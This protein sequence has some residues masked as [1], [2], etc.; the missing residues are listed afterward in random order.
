MGGREE[1]LAKLKEYG[2]SDYASR[3]YLALLEIGRA[4][5]RETSRQ[6]RVPLAKIYAVLRQLHDRGL[7]EVAAESPRKYAPR[8]FGEYLA[9]LRTEHDERSAALER[10]IDA[11]SAIFPE[12]DLLREAGSGHVHLV[13][14]RKNVMEKW[15]EQLRRAAKKD[16]LILA[17]DGFLQRMPTIL[18]V[19][20]EFA[21]AGGELK[22]LAADEP[23]MRGA[24]DHLGRIA[25]LR[26]KGVIEI[27]HPDASITLFDR[28]SA[29]IAH[30]SSRA[31]K[32]DHEDFAIITD[33]PTAVGLLWDV[34]HAHWDRARP[35][36]RSEPR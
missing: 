25:Q 19:L 21:A 27:E 28:E 17:G 20:E 7:V 8:P 36:P 34:L 16:V 18:P 33:L 3:V 15:R 32:L 13:R 12:P 22:V 9:K 10:D 6:S 11:A 4:D 1:Q 31:A 14:G 2:F 24:L 26:D 30:L 35:L 5:A 29:M 23:P